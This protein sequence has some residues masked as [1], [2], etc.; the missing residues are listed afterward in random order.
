MPLQVSFQRS[1][2]FLRVLAMHG[3]EAALGSYKDVG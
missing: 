1:L 2:G 3:R